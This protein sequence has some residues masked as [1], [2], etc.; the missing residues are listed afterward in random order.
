[1]D[2]DHYDRLFEHGRAH[3]DAAGHLNHHQPE[4]TFLLSVVLEQEKQVQDLEER[5]D[6]LEDDLNTPD[7]HDPNR[8]PA[9]TATGQAD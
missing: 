4:M 8:P 3:A 1:M 2:Q 9:T 7:D 5:V 6:A